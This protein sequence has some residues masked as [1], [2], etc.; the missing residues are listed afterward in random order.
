MTYIP[1][2]CPDLKYMT[3]P[4][5][6]GLIPYKGQIFKLGAT[7]SDKYERKDITMK[8]LNKNFYVTILKLNF[9]LKLRFFCIVESL[10]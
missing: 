4:A 6:F 8:R 5:S 10:S 7:P 1:G 9:S 2:R 3:L